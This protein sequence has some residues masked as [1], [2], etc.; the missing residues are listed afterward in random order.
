M[1]ALGTSLEFAEGTRANS[2]CGHD[3]GRIRKQDLNTGQIFPPVAG[4]CARP[5]PRQRSPAPPMFAQ[6]TSLVLV[7]CIRANSGCGHHIRRIRKEDLKLGRFGIFP[8]V[9]TSEEPG[10]TDVGC[11]DFFGVGRVEGSQ[12][13]MWSSHWKGP[14]RRPQNGSIWDFSSPLPVFMQAQRHGGGD[15]HP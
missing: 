14:K 13:R 15:K 9:V 10:N 11:G 4:L 12:L 5:V 7:E 1:L 6:G 2:G 3:I 8:P